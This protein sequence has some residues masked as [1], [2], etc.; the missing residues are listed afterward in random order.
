METPQKMEGAL[1]TATGGS[2]CWLAL[3][4]TIVIAAPVR[5]RGDAIKSRQGVAFEK[6]ICVQGT[7]TRML[8]G[9]SRR[10]RHLV[11]EV[12]SVMIVAVGIRPDR[13]STRLNS[14]H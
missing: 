10:L 7:E 4:P 6:R 14:S 3:A 1:L 2:R 11:H 5:R 9:Q 8:D 13:K 12:T